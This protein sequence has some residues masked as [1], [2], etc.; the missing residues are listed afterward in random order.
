MKTPGVC[1]GAAR[2]IRTR[3]PVWLLEGLRRDGASDG[4]LLQTYPQ[5]TANDLTQAWAYVE[6]N[7]EEIALNDKD[8]EDEQD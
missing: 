4:E 1:G 7:K 8:D 5:L 2:F 6:A 3:I